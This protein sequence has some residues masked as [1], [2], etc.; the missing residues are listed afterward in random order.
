VSKAENLKTNQSQIS[1]GPD[2]S[3]MSVAEKVLYYKKQKQNNSQLSTSHDG[4]IVVKD[5]STNNV[6]QNDLSKSSNNDSNLQIKTEM[7]NKHK[8]KIIT[9]Q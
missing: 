5:S 2:L 4:Q 3:K 6:S 7:I 1:E 9:S 8:M